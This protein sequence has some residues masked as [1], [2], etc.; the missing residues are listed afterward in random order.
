MKQSK[1]H[2]HFTT[3]LFILLK[4]NNNCYYVDLYMFIYYPFHEKEES[5]IIVAVMQW[6]VDIIILVFPAFFFLHLL[7]IFMYKDKVKLIEYL[8]RMSSRQW[9]GALR[10]DLNNGCEGYYRAGGWCGQFTTLSHPWCS[11]ARSPRARAPLKQQSCQ[12][13]LSTRAT[14][15][16]GQI[17]QILSTLPV[18]IVILA[19]RTH[20]RITH[21]TQQKISRP[22][23][24]VR[25]FRV[26]IFYG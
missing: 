5:S 19:T 26:N 13:G 18:S 24:V 8:Y 17:M 12:N 15:S 6:L 9:G 10:D 1:I 22:Y 21:Q 2:S 25:F 14:T 3:K 23:I 20:K 4:I 16:M 11:A 7:V